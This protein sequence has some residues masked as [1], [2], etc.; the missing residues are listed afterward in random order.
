EVL[1]VA[2]VAADVDFFA[3]G[4]H[5]LLAVRLVAAVRASLGVEL[6]L[7][8]LFDAP[9]PEALAARVDAAA[10][11]RAPLRPRP[12]PERVPLSPAQRRLW[13]L[14]QVEGAGAT[15]N[16]P[17][18]LRLTGTLDR[19]A[20]RAALG[21]VVA[22]HESL[23]TVF[24][25]VDGEPVQHVLPP[26]PLPLPVTAT[27]ADALPALL[28]ASARHGFDL[29][30]DVPLHA[31]LFS[32][33]PEEHALLL[34]AHHIASDG[35][36]MGALSRDVATAYTARL[37]GAAP[38]WAPLPVQYADHALWLAETA[39]DEADPDS[40]AARGLAFWRRALAG[41]PE[42]LDLPTDRP[43][44]TTT[45]HLGGVVPVVLPADL[46]RG[47]RAVALDRGASLFLVL[48]AALAAL[49]DKLGAGR[50]IPIGT[51]VAG[52]SDT[53]A[54]D[55][56]GFFVNTLVLRA[57]TSGDPTFTEL[58]DRVRETA[59][60]AYE[61]QDVPFERLVEALNP[62][63]SLAHNPLYQTLLAL[64]H[65]PLG[66][67]DPPGL[68]GVAELVHTGTAKC[69]LSL[70]LTET[71]TADGAP[72]GVTGSAEYSADLFDRDT[73]E[74]LVR[75]WLDLLRQ[76]VADPGRRL[77][78]FAVR[79]AAERPTTPQVTHRP[80]GA[81][82]ALFEARVDRAPDA[83]AV[84]CDGAALTYAEL[85]ARANRLARL[86]VERGAGP[87]R[88]VALSLPRSLDLVVAVLAV[89]KSGAAYLPVDPG[90]PPARVAF[91]LDDARPA[92]LVTAGGTA[93]EHALDLDAVDLDAVDWDAL[94]PA[95][96]AVAVHPECAA[97]VIYTS[98]STGT[99]KGVVVPHATVVRLFDATDHWFGFDEHDVW[100]LF[101]SYA[102]DFSVWELWGPLLHGGRLVVVPHGTS[103]SP[104]RFLELLERERVTVL[105]QT[106]S[107]FHQLDRAEREHPTTLDAL[108]YVVFGGEAL[109]LPRLADWYFRHADDAPA[110]V[111]M[112]G[113]TETT[114]HVTHT[115]LDRSRAVPGAPSDIGAAIPDLRA[116]VLDARLKPVPNGVTGELHIS[117]AGLARGYLNRPG[118]TATRFVADP[119]GEPGRRMYRTGDLARRNRHGALEFL[120]RA[121]HQ[122]KVRGFRIELGEIE[123]ALAEHPEVAQ[124]VVVARQD[125]ADD[126]RLVAYTVATPGAHPRPD[127]L[128]A[129][130]AQR[131]PAHMAPAAFVPLDAIPLTGN[132]KLDRK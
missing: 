28:A 67:F 99:P 118:L 64:Q 42:V 16:I 54:D 88:L 98:G 25:L 38:D 36:S 35:W 7:A 4:G 102:F 69:D 39:G 1:G 2:P 124:A 20:L 9:T 18:A 57:D 105:N 17:L 103:R 30:A 29:A 80:R 40:R 11:A 70:I 6:G 61:H 100:T 114:V 76:V 94:D 127:A 68:T 49:L 63:R 115:A 132:G 82:H 33:G 104:E 120:G 47:L 32:T 12:R 96:P 125:R 23:R 73:A 21:D 13:F 3:L 24:P 27:T 65:D 106:P 109:D 92:L 55:L 110:L 66:P 108:R 79:T 122:V 84:T 77:S 72:S 62:T 43:R 129:H 107:A 51:P 116:H 78:A 130:L 119:F 131:L 52:R 81:L 95:R 111:N 58:L 75:R 22:R 74:L 50:D 128:R 126:T 34:V 44:P 41:L 93:Q 8:D 15:Y 91:L 45:S 86:L 113:I 83:V 53:A 89:L 117:G 59:L 10:P 123:A 90:Y 85:D 121:D 60:A 71:T 101:H 48:Q 87:E 112:Y 56:V 46:H 97:Y 5:S 14:H 19:D 37:R 26:A 31:E